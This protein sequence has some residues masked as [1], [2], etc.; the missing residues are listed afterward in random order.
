MISTVKANYSNG[1]LTP[2]EPLDLQEGSEVTLH[3][4]NAPS[5]EQTPYPSKDVVPT[6]EP[7]QESVMEMFA[8]IRESVPES[9]WSDLPTDGA[10]NVRHYLYGRPKENEAT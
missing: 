8:R 6:A 2:L 10:M 3:I 1:V 7:R 9:A 5:P 4:E